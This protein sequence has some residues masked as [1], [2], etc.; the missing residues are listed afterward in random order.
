MYG[1]ARTCSPRLAPV[2]VG[3]GAS[4]ECGAWRVPCVRCIRN[5]RAASSTYLTMPFA[6][7]WRVAGTSGFG[8][9]KMLGHGID[10]SITSAAV[11]H[12]FF[13][14]RATSSGRAWLAFGHAYG[15]PF[16]LQT[17]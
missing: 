7:R 3:T 8:R 4:I 2:T 12:G 5:G 11:R 1:T 10:Q 13:P 16:D 14:D 6:S 15:L 9:S 17:T